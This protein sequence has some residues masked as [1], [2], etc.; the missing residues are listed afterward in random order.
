MSDDFLTVSYLV[1]LFV[2]FVLAVRVLWE[3]R[4]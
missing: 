1:V 2:C 4:K 3:I